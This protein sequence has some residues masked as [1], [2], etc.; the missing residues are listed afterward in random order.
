MPMI[1]R[2]IQ[3]FSFCVLLVFAFVFNSVFYFYKLAEAKTELNIVTVTF[4]SYSGITVTVDGNKGNPAI[5]K[6]LLS[7]TDGNGNAVEIDVDNCDSF[8]NK[9]VTIPVVSDLDSINLNGATVRFKKGFYVFEGGDVLFSEQVWIAENVQDEVFRINF[10][11]SSRGDSGKEDSARS[12]ESEEVFQSESIDESESEEFSESL[13]GAES[14]KDSESAGESDSEEL[15]ESYEELESSSESSGESSSENDDE[16]TSEKNEE[17]ESRD[18]SFDDSKSEE[19][20]VSSEE[21][22]ESSGDSKDNESSDES[23]DSGESEKE[24]SSASESDNSESDSR[25][26][27]K[28]ES[29]KAESNGN[30]SVKSQSEKTSD[31]KASEE[32]SKKTEE[33]LPEET[34]SDKKTGVVSVVAIG[35]V[36]VAIVAT[37]TT[38]FIKKR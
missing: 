3:I 19:S 11:K 21:S 23:E 33:E 34:D 29:D 28:N 1:K 35:G 17:S 32:E 15:S 2:L 31:E 14:E 22:D 5:D 26:S 13:I 9:D 36:I 18:E 38:I 30:E 8:G 20:V 16:N 27:G 12:S 24:S 10:V 37:S 7:V 4:D 6:N 25:E